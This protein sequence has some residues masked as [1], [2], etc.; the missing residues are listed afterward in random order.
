MSEFQLSLL[1]IGLIVVAGVYLYG[2][3]QQ[4]R[5]RRSQGESF[6]SQ[7]TDAAAKTAPDK[8]P[9]SVAQLEERND[10]LAGLESDSGSSAADEVRHAAG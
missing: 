9:A 4:W 8:A 3:W 5:Y 6:K 10:P 1:T 7:V 2:F